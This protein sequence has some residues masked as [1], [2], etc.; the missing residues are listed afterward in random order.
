MAKKKGSHKPRPPATFKVYTAYMFRGQDPAI[1]DVKRFARGHTN[2]SIEKDG[3]P[4]STTLNNWFTGKTRRPQNATLEAAG[5][6]LGMKRVWVP[7]KDTKNDE[8]EE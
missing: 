8:S 6:A 2:T 4:A 7:L 1:A 3:G 5:R